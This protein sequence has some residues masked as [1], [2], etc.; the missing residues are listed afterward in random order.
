MDAISEEDEITF[1]RI[2]D[3]RN[4]VAH[5]LH[6]VLHGEKG[7]D[8]GAQFPPLMELVLKIE[9]WWI[10]NVELAT[11]PEADLNAV[12]EDGILPGRYWML[13][14]LADVALGE[15][16]DP[17]KFYYAAKAGSVTVG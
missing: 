17:W 12:D 8:F 15:G 6:R 10:V 5:E 1:R 9:K 16:E 14:V 7:V 11:D 3:A 2:T 13:Q 4:S